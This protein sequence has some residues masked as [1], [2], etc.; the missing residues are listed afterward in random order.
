MYLHS[1][2]TSGRAI[3]ITPHC[4]AADV[5]SHIAICFLLIF[6][7]FLYSLYSFPYSL[8]S[9]LS[10][11]GAIWPGKERAQDQP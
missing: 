4:A 11:T 5:F 9:G 6:C 1:L 3:H 2:H 7:Y 10:V 8:L